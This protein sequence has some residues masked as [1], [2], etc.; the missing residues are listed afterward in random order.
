MLQDAD[1]RPTS[2]DV[3]GTAQAVSLVLCND[4]PTTFGAPDV[5][6]FCA[7]NLKLSFTLDQSFSDR[8]PNQVY[9]HCAHALSLVLAVVSVNHNLAK[10]FIY[11][12]KVDAESSVKQNGTRFPLLLSVNLGACCIVRT[13][14]ACGSEFDSFRRW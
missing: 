2:V 5:L 8:P 3:N 1:F 9:S 12:A 10:I 13:H 14:S 4:K 11:H 6:D 7:D